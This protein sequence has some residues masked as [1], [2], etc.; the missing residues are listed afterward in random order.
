[1]LDFIDRV[2][3]A[4]ASGSGG[5]GDGGSEADDG[6][7]T[8]LLILLGVGAGGIGLV[9]ISRRRRRAREEAAQAEKLR[10]FAREDVVAL[11][12]ALRELDPETEAVNADPRA[13]VELA[14][15]G[16]AFH[17]ADDALERARRPRDFEGVTSAVADGRYAIE[18]TKAYLAGR[19]PPERRPPCFFDPR[20]GSSTRDVEWAPDGGEVRP[21][22]ACEADAQRVERGVD[23]DSRQVLVG[24]ASTPYWNAP[25][26]FGP[27][28]VGTSE[29]SASAAASSPVFS[30]AP[31]SEVGCWG[32]E[33][34][35]TRI[36]AITAT[37][38]A[39]PGASGTSAAAISAGEGTS[40][41]GASGAAISGAAAATSRRLQRLLGRFGALTPL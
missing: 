40:A 7:P 20:H 26:Y 39:V 4:R 12:D 41:A 21:V 3:R 36:P 13:T 5:G 22:P 30:S 27:W 28:A 19:E 24:G 15:A 16:D 9:A 17:R 23:P 35:H 34:P 10:E 25:G 31:C 37:Q 6:S 11:A 32:G 8:G 38:A 33:V 1:M 14:K 18:C 29:G 2:G